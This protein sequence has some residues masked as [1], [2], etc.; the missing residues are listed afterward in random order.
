M[1]AS[2]PTPTE[3]HFAI[4]QCSLGSVLVARS[5][6]GVCAVLL[7]DEPEAVIRE[8]AQRFPGSVLLR[9]DEELG[10]SLAQVVGLVEAPGQTLNLLIDLRGTTFQQ[11]VWQALREIPPGT[12]STYTEVAGR[13]GSPKAVRAVA[14]ACAGNRLALVV[15]CHRVI[16]SDGALSGYRWGLERKRILLQR[17]EVAR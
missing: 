12:T 5:E 14:R 8:L 16:G 7:G 6:H 13:I 10:H 2:R 4:G 15:P 17:E 11:R 9:Q 3:L 1:K